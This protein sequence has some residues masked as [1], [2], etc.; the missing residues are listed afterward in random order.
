MKLW[1]VP[2]RSKLETPNPAWTARSC[3]PTCGATAQTKAMAVANDGEKRI[4]RSTMEEARNTH[5]PS[6]E[7]RRASGCRRRGTP[8]CPSSRTRP[9]RTARPGRLSDFVRRTSAATLYPRDG[10]AAFLLVGAGAGG[11]P[12]GRGCR[13]DVRDGLLGPG[14]ERL[15]Q[16]VRGGSRRERGEGRPTASRGGG[17]RA[18]GRPRR[19]N[20]AR[21]RLPGRGRGA[22][23]RL[24]L[25]PEYPAPARLLRYPGARVSRFP[26]RSG[27]RD[28]L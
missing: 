20:C 12:G 9:W 24:R 17:D 14:A 16:S 3:A 5:D 11:V 28:L 21:A 2:D 19:G 10:A 18:C 4:M 26:Q 22:V 25:D 23:S 13:L 7:F 8:V 1:P 6:L 27:S 15:G